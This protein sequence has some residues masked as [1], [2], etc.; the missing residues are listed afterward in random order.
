MSLDTLKNMIPD[1]AKDMRLNL[2]GITNT[3]SLTTQQLWGTILSSALATRNATVIKAANDE[4]VNH[5]SEDALNAAKSAAAIMGM[6]N[7]YYRF[8]HL[9]EKADY[10]QMPARLRM[11]VLATPGVEK[12]DFELWSI[13]VSAING[14]GM[15]ITS[16]EKVLI[17]HGM[18]KAAIQDAIRIASILHAIAAIIDGE[19]AMNG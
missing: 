15:C 14:C 16:H 10:A 19:K 8:V 17:D 2:S 6:N 12:T 7:I 18:Q 1:Y 4:A 13:A 9:V 3:P 11:N 5:L